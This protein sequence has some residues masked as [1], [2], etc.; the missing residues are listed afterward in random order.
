MIVERLPHPWADWAVGVDSCAAA[1]LSGA[2]CRGARPTGASGL[3]QSHERA[4]A[5]RWTG[6]Q[7]PGTQCVPSV[8]LQLARTHALLVVPH[9]ARQQPAAVQQQ[10]FHSLECCCEVWAPTATQQPMVP[11]AHATAPM[12]SRL[13]GRTVRIGPARERTRQ[14]CHSAP[15]RVLGLHDEEGYEPTPEAGECPGWECL[16][17][18][19]P[20]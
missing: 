3:L 14:R 17:N 5:C 13:H 2:P 7:R 4:N 15:V 12:P 9:P 11:L 20:Q 16:S 1:M 10:A 18:A 8:P 19:C 6:G